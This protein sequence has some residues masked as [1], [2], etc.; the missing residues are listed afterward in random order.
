MVVLLVVAL[1][2]EV[3]LAVVLLV[4]LLLVVDLGFFSFL[5]MLSG[6]YDEPQLV[7]SKSLSQVFFSLSLSLKHPVFAA[8][9]FV[10]SKRIE[11]SFRSSNKTKI[12]TM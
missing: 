6:Y 12:L 11:F 2:V 9:S 7:A 4:V 1:L 3:L 8:D 5:L 10:E